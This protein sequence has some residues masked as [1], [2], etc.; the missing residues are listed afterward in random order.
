M[1]TLS[2]YFVFFIIFYQNLTLKTYNQEENIDNFRR[3]YYNNNII[4]D[5]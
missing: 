3:S 2:I 5:L 1:Y 4:I